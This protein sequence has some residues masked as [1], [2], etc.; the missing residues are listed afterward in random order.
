MRTRH[1]EFVPRAG[2]GSRG[3]QKKTKKS[4]LREHTVPHCARDM[5]NF[6]KVL[7]AHARWGDSRVP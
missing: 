7:D 2:A 4:V 5:V 6:P 1:G 3:K